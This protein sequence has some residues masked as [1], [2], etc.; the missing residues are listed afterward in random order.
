MILGSSGS[1]KSTLAKQMSGVL[2]LPAIHLD[3]LYWKPGWQAFGI[4][5][6]QEGR[7]L[8]P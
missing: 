2:G 4:G 6:R 1:G 3:G 7:K 8:L 5:R